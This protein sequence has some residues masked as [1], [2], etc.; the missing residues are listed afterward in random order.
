MKK[1]RISMVVAVLM[2]LCLLTACASATNTSKSTSAK[3]DK[4]TTDDKKN[5][6]A[7]KELTSVRLCEVAHSIFYAPMYVAIEKGYF[8]EEGIDLSLK[9]GFG[10][11]K[12]MTAVLSGESDIGFMGSE[13][14]IYT[15]QEGANNLI[16]NFAQLTQRAGNFLV[17]REDMSDFTW[18]D[19][20]GKTVLGGRAGGM[21]EMV[22]EYILK[23]NGI[24][25]QKDLTINQS[26]DFGSTAAAFAEGLADYTVEFE[27]SAT[28]LE[29]EGKGYVVAS[30]G[31]DSGY[32][33]YTSFSAKESYIEA[34]PDIIQGF[35]NALQKGMDYVQ[36][37]SPSEIA[38][39]IKP[40]F[41]ETD[42]DTIT[43]IVARYYDQDTWKSDLIFEKESFELLQ[44]IL[45]SSGVL[46]ERTPY[47][48]L[49]TTKYAEEAVK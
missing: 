40:Q 36:K 13:S 38:T 26:I 39:V 27:P 49:V 41:K 14:T 42:L 24:D 46:K 25:P 10:A 18:T 11:D 15:Y 5:S 8:E 2:C 33:P 43:T 29:K 47:K 45:D 44:D 6:D 37:H 17:A 7:P 31:V 16:V 19:L 4:Q 23:Q 3:A 20:K 21:P 32:V 28:S 1:K 34:N 30:L 9:N 48:E 35:T 22:F 12:V